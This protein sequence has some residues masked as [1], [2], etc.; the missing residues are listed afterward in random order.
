MADNKTRFETYY[1]KEDSGKVV[2]QERTDGLEEIEK[3]LK[4]IDEIK[5]SDDIDE[6]LHP[7]LDEIH[8]QI[9]SLRYSDIPLAELKKKIAKYSR[10]PLGDGK[11]LHLSSFLAS[12]GEQKV[13][14]TEE[15]Y[16]AQVDKMIQN[17]KS[18]LAN[19]LIFKEEDAHLTGFFDELK[20]IE[21]NKDYNEVKMRMEHLTMSGII[22]HYN[23]IKL[24]FLKSWLAPFEEK[25][26]KKVDMMSP[27]E[28]QAALT[29]VDGLKKQ[30][31][32]QIGLKMNSDKFD[33]FHPYNRSMHELM[34][35]QTTDFW[36]FPEYRDEFVDLVKKIINRFSFKL[37]RH[38]LIFESAD[39]K[40][41][42]L[43]GFPSDLFETKKDLKGGKIGF[44]PHLKI[45]FASEKGTY[46]EFTQ[47][48][49]EKPAD[50]F[51][52]LKTAVVPFL[53]SMSMIV[54]F[55]LSQDFKQAFD[56][57]L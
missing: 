5:K 19:L 30:E 22:K 26:G 35:G 53:S 54:D 49:V 13:V 28:I 9:Q 15:E 51:R 37:E 8:F 48:S 55:E 25:L 43:M 45:F 21:G 24:D 31:L 29:K 1:A 4:L 20:H 6:A 17:T 39:Q 11:F 41:A 34:N 46:K 32:E 33:E 40:M 52:T 36:G 12:T 14:K 18:N 16:L 27:K 47:E 57:W 23:K 56:M 44:S 3:Y 2:F 10:V 38:F 7:S 42:Y 50:Y